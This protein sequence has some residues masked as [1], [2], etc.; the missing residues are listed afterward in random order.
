M[1]CKTHDRELVT[2]GTQSICPACM[3]G[4]CAPATRMWDSLSER[5]A[6]A[7]QQVRL[8]DAAIPDE[9]AGKDF[10]TF[11][12]DTERAARVVQVLSSYCESFASTR[13]KRKGFLLVGQPGTAKT[14]LAC[15][16]VQSVVGQGFRGGYVNLPRLT[17]EIRA[18]Y[19]R[20]R[21]GEGLLQKVMAFDL[22]IVD[23]IDLHGS[24]DNDY[25]TL[26]DIINTRYEKSGYPTVA[27]SN[28][29]LEH[30]LRDLDERIVSRILAGTSPILCDWPSRRG[31][32]RARQEAAHG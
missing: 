13:H 19:G 23:E 25:S 8:K 11:Q 20:P 10:A 21:A 16:M 22:L 15:A 5:M 6:T 2:L 1:R 9:F 32:G 12:A 3:A 18:T 7:E 28:R 30:L 26:Y 14:H 24:S 17:R 4:A 31:V 27:I 29:P